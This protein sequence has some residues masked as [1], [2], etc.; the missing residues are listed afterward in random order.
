M[1]S[2]KTNFIDPLIEAEKNS[3]MKGSFG[4]TFKTS[5]GYRPHIIEITDLI[6]QSSK[7]IIQSATADCTFC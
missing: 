4:K 2:S 7:P 6:R 5:K 1:F 3:E